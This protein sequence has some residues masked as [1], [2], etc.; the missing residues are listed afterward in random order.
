[1]DITVVDADGIRYSKYNVPFGDDVFVQTS[2][3]R[4]FGWGTAG[5]GLLGTILYLIVYPYIF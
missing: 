3:E 2:K 1:M 5:L 4:Y